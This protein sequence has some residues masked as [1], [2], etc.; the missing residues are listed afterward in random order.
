MFDVFSPA[1]NVTNVVIARMTT[2]V[3][4]NINS[5]AMDLCFPSNWLLDFAKIPFFFFL[6]TLHRNFLFCTGDKEFAGLYIA[7]Q[8]DIG[9][10]N[11]AAA[12]ALHT[13]GHIILLSHI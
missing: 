13:A 2:Y 12:P 6:K 4:A 8:L 11:I 5:T 9:G 7:G 3:M 1:V 10:A